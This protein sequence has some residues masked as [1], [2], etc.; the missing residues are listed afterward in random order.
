MDQRTHTWLAI[1]A[2]A[3]LE[4]LG[5]T[6]GLLGILKPDIRS[7]AIGAWI[8]DLQ[9][10]K[11][12][13]GDIDNHV[14]KMKPYGG[15]QKERFTVLKD[16]LLKQLGPSRRMHRLIKQDNVL[17]AGWWKTPYRAE[18]KPGQHIANRAMALTTTILDQLILGDSEVAALV[19]G[20]VKFAASMDPNAL[21]RQ[22]Q[23]A[24]YFF[25]LSHFIG[26]S[27]MPCH[28][29]AR[30]LSAYGNGLHKELERHWA[31]KVGTYFEKGNLLRT[32]DSSAEILDRARKVDEEFG[33]KFPKAIPALKSGDVWM[34]TVAVC[35]GS[36]ALA[37]ILAPVGD[38]PFGGK[39]KA[40]FGNLFVGGEGK[41]LLE[42]IDN[43][44]MHDS[45]L[46]IAV[47]WKHI[48]SRF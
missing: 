44:V 1:R 38:F 18:P 41:L 6:P 13:S 46:N 23:A 2:V 35:R 31:D 4:N 37:S 28:C 14:F 11:K 21:T 15:E 10:S 3:L 26:D 40:L 9:E 39:E 22:E 45:V 34:E 43:A 33:I 25:M 24:T 17:S 5:E 42:K 16:E 29:D 7:T 36:F 32:G 20:T 19:P 47:V 27:C 30:S 8:P 12:G 48:W